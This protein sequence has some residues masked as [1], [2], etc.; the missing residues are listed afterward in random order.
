MLRFDHTDTDDVGGILA[1][2]WGG[3]DGNKG[4]KI[5]RSWMV[6]VFHNQQG[7]TV[8]LFLFITSN[9]REITNASLLLH[10]IC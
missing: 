4:A 10:F 3:E 2:L 9:H 1:E 7:Q 8:Y 5:G 6:W